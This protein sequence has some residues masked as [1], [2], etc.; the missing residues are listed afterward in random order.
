ML[1]YAVSMSLVGV[2][3]AD[4]K[5]PTRA[6]RSACITRP[7]LFLTRLKMSSLTHSNH[8]IITSL[9]INSSGRRITLAQV[10]S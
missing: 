9:A 3:C 7:A 1:G 6:P 5:S 10:T 2:L 4:P 8:I